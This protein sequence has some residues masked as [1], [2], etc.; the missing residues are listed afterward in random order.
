MGRML[1]VGMALVWL[2]LLAA[3]EV[4]FRA[5]S[6][7]VLVG[8]HAVRGDEFVRDLRPGD[9]E[10]LED[11]QPRTVAVFEGGIYYRRRLPMHVVLLFDCSNSVRASGL[12]NPKVF[13]EG[14]LATSP[15]VSLGI[16]GF[17]HI[18][19]HVVAPTRRIELLEAGVE[20]IVRFAPG[21]T[22]LY[23]AIVDTVGELTREKAQATRA[24]VIFSDSMAP[25][26]QQPEA[27]RLARENDISLYPVVLA[28]NPKDLFARDGRLN[29]Y[30]KTI[31]TF[32]EIARPTG[33]REFRP[34]W[35][36]KS[37]LPLILDEMMLQA[38]A[39]YVVG[40]YAPEGGEKKARRVEVRLRS[41]QRGEVRGG[42]RVLVN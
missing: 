28:R 26:T 22:R 1:R 20:E 31:R 37:V 2:P 3:Q 7:L 30:E 14:M 16:S 15:Q 25:P 12:L 9:V 17:T 18:T 29:P 5:D 32:V 24:M 38:A 21:L 36:Q 13:D 4:T 11:G 6:R 33:G 27:I 8:F 39:E 41:P 35:S 40:Y 23:E 34:K 42:E 10:I 19:R